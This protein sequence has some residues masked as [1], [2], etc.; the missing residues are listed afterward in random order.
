MSQLQTFVFGNQWVFAIVIATILLGI[1]EAGYRVG[2][3]LFSAHDEARRSQIGGVQGAV[4]GL[5]GLLLG[6]TFSMAVNRFETRRDLVLTEAN[7]I[8]T[9]WLRADLLP[10]VHRP[11]VKE[12]LRRFVDVRVE[13]QRLSDDPA[14]LAEGLRLSA[15]LENDLWRHASAAAGEAPT[16]ITATFINSLNEMIDTDAARQ[17]AGRNDIPAAVWFLLLVVAGSGCLTSAY[18]SGAQGARSAF[19]SAF[20]PLLITVVIVLIFDLMHTHQGIVSI[21]QQPMLDLQQAMHAQVDDR[22]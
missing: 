22:S 9:T 13:Y 5:L 7:A 8:G 17:T 10:E 6:F 3:R 18:G 15:E 4:L 21:D 19:T 1:S 11:A 20:L 16:P 12:L 14:R 2:L